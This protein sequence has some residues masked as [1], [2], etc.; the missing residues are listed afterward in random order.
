[1]S[2]G[3]AIASTA[4]APLVAVIEAGGGAA[5]AE[6]A[7][8]TTTTTTTTASAP[9]TPMPTPTATPTTTT[10]MGPIDIEHTRVDVTSLEPI[11]KH[12]NDLTGDHY[13]VL[14]A[15]CRGD[16]RVALAAT[17]HSG[18]HHD[19]KFSIADASA[20][21]SS[22]TFS[23]RQDSFIFP[24]KAFYVEII[25]KPCLSPTAASI[26]RVPIYAKK[27]FRHSVVVGGDCVDKLR[28][29]QYDASATRFRF[30]AVGHIVQGKF[31]RKSV[32]LIV[33]TL[34]VQSAKRLLS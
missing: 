7:L 19:H 14:V 9:T 28:R 18:T 25:R 16:G 26:L 1:M 29:L 15:L 6:A 8:T 5:E 21:A 33:L 13:V 31:D 20:A 4:T 27:V 24:E 30:I 22:Q 2:D 10:T 32:L 11:P 3:P 34:V 17:G 23:W 12:D